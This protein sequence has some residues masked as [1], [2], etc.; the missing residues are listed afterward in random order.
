[1]SSVARLR[2]A[3]TELRDRWRH[4]RDRLRCQEVVELVTEYLDGAL[5]P[6]VASRFEYHLARCPECTRYLAQIEL[7]RDAMGR[8]RPPAP[9]ADARAA[10]LD[11]Y[12]DVHSN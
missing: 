5:D 10:L 8:L 11:A 9:P 7:T 2:Q 4:R 12:R 1:M 6:R 3:T